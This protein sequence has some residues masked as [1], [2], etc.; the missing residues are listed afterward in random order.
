MLH[1][2]L[3]MCNDISVGDKSKNNVFSSCLYKHHL[4]CRDAPKHAKIFWRMSGR[5]LKAYHWTV[6]VTVMHVRFPQDWLF[7]LVFKVRSCARENYN[8]GLALERTRD[9]ISY[10]GTACCTCNSCKLWFGAEAESSR[11]DF[12]ACHRTVLH[13]RLMRRFEMWWNI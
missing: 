1:P 5:H 13:V 11:N 3:G 12:V 7:R 10:Q 2:S 4:S 8:L 6:T 9:M